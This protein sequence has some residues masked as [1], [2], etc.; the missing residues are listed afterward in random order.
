MIAE[1][2]PKKLLDVINVKGLTR[3]NVASH[4]QKYRLYLKRLGGETPERHPI[5][6]FQASGGGKSGGTMYILPGGRRSS[7][8]PPTKGLNLRTGITESNVGPQDLDAGTMRFLPVLKASQ[9]QWQRSANRA[10]VL[11]VLGSVGSCPIAAAPRKPS[12]DLHPHLQVP[13]S[14]LLSSRSMPN[15][16]PLMLDDEMAARPHRAQVEGF[17]SHWNINP[18]G[19]LD[20][21]INPAN[22][23]PG[24]ERHAC[25]EGTQAGIYVEIPDGLNLS[26]CTSTTEMNMDALDLLETPEQQLSVSDYLLDGEF[27]FDIGGSNSLLI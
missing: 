20:G 6:S 27:L 3:E 18:V 21:N 2:V 16:H 24:D 11:D 26:S 22:L 5:A 10:E 17:V 8:V 7:S 13:Q 9:Q 25:S 15:Y 4:L 1:A 19:N 23:T 12:F 14:H